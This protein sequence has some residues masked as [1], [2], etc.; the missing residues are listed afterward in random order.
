MSWNKRREFYWS[1][2]IC[3]SFDSFVAKLR[4]KCLVIFSMSAERNWWTKKQS[5][6]Y[7]INFWWR[8]SKVE[9]RL[10]AEVECPRG[11]GD[12]K[13][14]LSLSFCLLNKCWTFIYKTVAIAYLASLF[15]LQVSELKKKQDAQAQLLRQKQKSDEAAKRLQ[16]EIQR[17]KTQKVPKP[18]YSRNCRY[19]LTTFQF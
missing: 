7:L 5:W 1:V 18:L 15:C 13:I 17:I 10:F 12:Y 4:F 6:K 2:F 3:H 16:D 14:T 11:T 8:C 19:N 9:G